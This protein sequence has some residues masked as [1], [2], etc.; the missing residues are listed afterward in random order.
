MSWH[1]DTKKNLTDKKKVT[2]I[3]DLVRKTYALR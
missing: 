3:A 1:K 2:F